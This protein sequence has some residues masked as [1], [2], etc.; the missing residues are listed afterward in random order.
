MKTVNGTPE[1]DP[2]RCSR[3][4]GLVHRVLPFFPVN[5]CVQTIPFHAVLALAYVA[6]ELKRQ[7]RQETLR[8][9][10]TSRLTTWQTSRCSSFAP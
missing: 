7:T 6:W 3:R 1:D 9:K 5:Q 4:R 2:P 8:R 10:H